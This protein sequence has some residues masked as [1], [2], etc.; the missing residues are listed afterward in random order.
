MS[1]FNLFT[2]NS[3]FLYSNDFGFTNWGSYTTPMTFNPEPS[4]FTGSF[5]L[6]TFSPFSFS[7]P[8]TNFQLPIFSNF[9]PSIP[10]PTNMFSY[11][12]PPTFYFNSAQ[13]SRHE[14]YHSTRASSGTGNNKYLKYKNTKDAANAAKNDPNLENISGGGS[15]W[16]ISENSFKTDIPFAKKGTGQILDIIWSKLNIKGKLTITS[17]LATGAPGSPHVVSSNKS[18][19]NA[20]N[21][22]LDILYPK[23][24]ANNHAGFKKLLD[25]TGLFSHTLAEGDHIDVQISAE[26]YQKF[27]E[28]KLA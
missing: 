16:A 3:N 21:P 19:H 5:G 14:T 15:H 10:G 18:H 7:N 11:F 13:N 22:K 1:F 12:Q 8:F 24:Y 23:E 4:I 2:N 6:P 20:D 26:T 9:V 27:Y 17:A 28:G 25:S